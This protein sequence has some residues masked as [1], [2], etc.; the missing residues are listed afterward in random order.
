MS[1]FGHILLVEFCRNKNKPKIKIFDKKTKEM[2][3]VF[4]WFTENII[5]SSTEL[6]NDITEQFFILGDFTTK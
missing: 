1:F 3:G 6:P 2:L 5:K 4:T